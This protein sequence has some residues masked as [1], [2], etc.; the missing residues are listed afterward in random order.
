V[1]ALLLVALCASPTVAVSLSWSVAQTEEFARE[2]DRLL[3]EMLRAG[4]RGLVFLERTLDGKGSRPRLPLGQRDTLVLDHL[5]DLGLAEITG[6]DSHV[7]ASGTV[8]RQRA[9]LTALGREQAML[10]HPQ[11]DEEGSDGS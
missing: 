3:V 1:S 2:E 7:K 6:T 11:D 10:V 4:E 5:I 9:R 8:I